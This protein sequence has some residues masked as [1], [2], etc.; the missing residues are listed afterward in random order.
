MLSPVWTS[1]LISGQAVSCL[2]KPSYVSTRHRMSRQGISPTL[3]TLAVCTS[4][5]VSSFTLSLL[6]KPAFITMAKDLDLVIFCW[7]EMNNDRQTIH[8][9]KQLGIDAI[10]YDRCPSAG[11]APLSPQSL[12]YVGP[13]GLFVLVGTLLRRKILKLHHFYWLLI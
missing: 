5:G 8:K 3:L 12:C 1:C 11:L 10:I 9:L 13:V 7:G 2:D 4:Q 6:D